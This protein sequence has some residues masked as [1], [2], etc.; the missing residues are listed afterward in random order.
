M[1]QAKKFNKYG[2]H[3]IF[4]LLTNYNDVIL[5]APGKKESD[6]NSL[7]TLGIN[8]KAIDYDPKFNQW[9]YYEIADFIFDKVDLTTECLVH[10]N[11][12]KTYYKI[13]YTGDIILRGDDR[14]KNGDCNPITSCEQLIEQYQL[15]KVYET[16]V[17]DFSKYKQYVVWGCR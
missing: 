11:C 1:K 8:V 15:K 5:L 14:H 3:M 12:E 16:Y 13:N 10:L 7:I 6:I 9:P 4:S 2:V 17:Q